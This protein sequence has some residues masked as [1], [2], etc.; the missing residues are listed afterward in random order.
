MALSVTHS[1]VVVV[2]DDGTSPVGTD[3]WNAAHTLTGTV[4]FANGG[5]NPLEVSTIRTAPWDDFDAADATSMTGR[6]MPSGHTW[7]VSGAGVADAV[8]SKQGYVASAN[9]LVYAFVSD[10]QVI[11]EIQCVISWRFSATQSG[12]LSTTGVI[13]FSSD[14]SNPVAPG[15]SKLLH[16]QFGGST[17]NL[18][19]SL[20]GPAGL[21]PLTGTQVELNGVPA[22]DGTYYGGNLKLDGT[23]Y[24]IRMVT[25]GNTLTIY[26]P[27]GVVWQWTDTDIGTIMA[28]C[29]TAFWEHSGN[30]SLANAAALYFNGCAIG[31]S[32]AGSVIEASSCKDT[33]ILR[34]LFAETGNTSGNGGYV[35]RLTSPQIIPLT[36]N[37]WYTIATHSLDTASVKMAGIV[38]V[39]GSDSSGRK[40]FLKINV[41]TE[42]GQPLP[43]MTLS[44]DGFLSLY[45]NGIV[46]FVRLS[47]NNT[48]HLIQLDISINSPSSSG[49]TLHANYEGYF[50]AVTTPVVGATALATFSVVAGNPALYTYQP[51]KGMVGRV[52][53]L[54]PAASAPQGSRGFV[55]NSNATL[56]A[57]LGNVV[58]GAG[59]NLVPIYNDGT[60]WRI[61]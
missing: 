11:S 59:A 44:V 53:D 5:P 58:A 52:A 32:K 24:K 6:V 42:D 14:A 2:P 28:S 10:T 46:D 4:P 49:A 9:G 7:S 31:P 30:T 41:G 25:S 45:G 61:G 51:M 37:G 57:G 60:N 55:N 17:W 54:P 18:L 19:K 22:V 16:L 26:F 3:E 15:T 56:A 36:G 1:T 38:T 20:T 50:T 48:T 27:D 29:Q 21:T 34:G 43:Y 13:G 39:W 12:V 8:I 33:A 40:V 23:R 47:Q 35:A